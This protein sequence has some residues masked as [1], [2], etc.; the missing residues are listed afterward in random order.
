MEPTPLPDPGGPGG[1]PWCPVSM[2]FSPSLPADVWQPARR[3]HWSVQR[4][5]PGV[6]TERRRS[7]RITLD[8]VDRRVDPDGPHESDVALRGRVHQYVGYHAGNPGWFLT[9]HGFA[10]ELAATEPRVAEGL[11]VD[12]RWSAR[13]VGSKDRAYNS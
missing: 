5:Q 11:D 3:R 9:P 6:T 4:R 12:R 10:N 7:D 8:H 13:S 2:P 1:I